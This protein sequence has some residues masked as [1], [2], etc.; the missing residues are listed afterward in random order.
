MSSQNNYPRSSSVNSTPSQHGATWSKMNPIFGSSKNSTIDQLK[1]MV[2][3]AGSVDGNMT[4]GEPIERPV[5]ARSTGSDPGPGQ[6]GALSANGIVLVK[7]ED[8]S[9]E[10]NVLGSV[11]ATN[12]NQ[13]D[14]PRSESGF[15]EG[16]NNEDYCGVC[17]N[18]GQLLC[19]D[20]CPKVY[21]LNCHIPALSDLPRDS[22]SCGLCIEI[23]QETRTSTPVG[24]CGQ[25]RRYSKEMTEW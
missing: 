8:Q 12:N 4:S 25:K 22:W 17:R 10:S 23:G 1:K 7:Q 9:P 11:N 16:Q 15:D 3:G 6:S 21:H 5:S 24:A 18:G 19:C 2:E 13:E 20:T 14:H